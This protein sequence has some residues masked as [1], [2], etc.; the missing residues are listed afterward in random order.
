M[1]FL[2]ALH[3]AGHLWVYKAEAEVLFDSASTLQSPSPAMTF[4]TESWQWPTTSVAD[5][6]AVQS[7]IFILTESL[8]FCKLLHVISQFL[9]NLLGTAGQTDSGA[10]RL[11]REAM[12]DAAMH[13]FSRAQR[14]E[15]LSGRQ[16]GEHHQQLN[17]LGKL[18]QKSLTSRPKRAF[19]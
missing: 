15:K 13:L 2:Q 11:T 8:H 1:V 4:L 17:T 10:E 3:T 5:A 18:F 12:Q 19:A 6:L 16:D 7:A 14:L 9:G